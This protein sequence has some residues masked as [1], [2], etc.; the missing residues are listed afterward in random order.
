M[1]DGHHR[2]MVL[3]ERGVTVDTLPR[4]VVPRE[5][6]RIVTMSAKIFWIP[7]PWRGRLGI[8]PRPRGADW[9]GDKTR[10]WRETGIDVVV[11]LLEP[12]E[13]ADSTSLVNQPRLALAASAF[14][15]S[16]YPIEVFRLS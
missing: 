13:E 12:D 16:Q 9:L 3:R 4:E 1:L 5:G 10:A 6:A 15:P 2:I 14:E 7:G 11:S 8:V